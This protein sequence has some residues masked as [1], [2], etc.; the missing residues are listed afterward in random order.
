MDSEMF[1]MSAAS[2]KHAGQLDAYI[3]NIPGNDLNIF[4][5]V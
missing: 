1:G 5:Q 2:G 4:L 3:K